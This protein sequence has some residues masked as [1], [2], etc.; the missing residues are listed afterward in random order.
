MLEIKILSNPERFESFELVNENSSNSSTNESKDKYEHGDNSNFLV[1]IIS[2]WKSWS[3]KRSFF[4]SGQVDQ[5]Q[6]VSGHRGRSFPTIILVDLVTNSGNKK[7]SS[8]NLLLP[9]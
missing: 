8:P 9:R 4:G 7:T 3:N 5:G 1:D 6:T 2:I